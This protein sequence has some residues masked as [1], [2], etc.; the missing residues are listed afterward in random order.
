MKSF[1][2]LLAGLV[3]SAGGLLG[4]WLLSGETTPTTG[5]TVTEGT[6]SYQPRKEID[7]NGV[8][9]FRVLA[10]WKDATSLEDIRASWVN[11][12]KRNIAVADDALRRGILSESD[13]ID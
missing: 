13:Q 2:V 9:E 3:L 10:E 6:S 4:F 8:A 7:T 5:P 1:L 11:L 12:G